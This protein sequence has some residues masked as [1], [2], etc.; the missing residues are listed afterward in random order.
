MQAFREFYLHMFGF[1][2]V[3]LYFFFRYLRCVADVL[4]NGHGL[5]GI[6]VLVQGAASKLKESNI[7]AYDNLLR[8]IATQYLRVKERG[9]RMAALADL[10]RI[11]SRR[12]LNKALKSAFEAMDKKEVRTKFIQIGKTRFKNHRAKAYQSMS[13]TCSWNMK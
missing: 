4:T 8:T 9:L 1:I 7:A 5:A 13:R 2:S 3:S 10:C 11:L 6:R 12:Q